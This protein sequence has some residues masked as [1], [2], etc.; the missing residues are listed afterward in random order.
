MHEYDDSLM[1]VEMD[2]MHVPPIVDFAK[3]K[4]N[5]KPDFP[6]DVLQ[7]QEADG[8]EQFEHNWPD[9]KKANAGTGGLLDLL[10]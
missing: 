9:E 8:L 3:V 10:P 4:L 1:V 5:N 7:Q 6:E 2:L